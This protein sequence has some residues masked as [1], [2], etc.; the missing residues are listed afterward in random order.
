MATEAA[1]SRGDIDSEIRRLQE[2]NAQMKVA[3]Q[4]LQAQKDQLETDITRLASVRIRG[5]PGVA[6][7]SDC[8]RCTGKRG[9]EQTA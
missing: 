7:S 6:L 5:Q 3:N 4:K 1:A 9:H 2:R 8:E